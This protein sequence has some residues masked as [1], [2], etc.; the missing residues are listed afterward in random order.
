MTAIGVMTAT[1]R[2]SLQLLA[3]AMLHLILQACFD[4]GR[5]LQTGSPPPAGHQSLR[6]QLDM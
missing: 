3:S 1:G 4:H 6:D 2:Y 5:A